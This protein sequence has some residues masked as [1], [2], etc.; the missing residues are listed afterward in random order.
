MVRSEIPEAVVLENSHN[1]GFAAANNQ[2]IRRAR[3]EFVLL[4]NPDTEI[5]PGSLQAMVDFMRATPRAGAA[6]G[7]L[8]NPDGSL[9]AS[10]SP[11]PTLARE[12]W[13]LIH[14]D[15][16]RPLSLYPLTEWS[17]GG[18]RSVDVVQ[19]AALILRRSALDEVGFLDEDYFMYTEEVDLCYR[20]RRSGWEVFWL[21]HAKVLHWGGQS[22][23]QRR[24]E[25][26]LRLYES[27][28]IFFRKRHGRL[29]ALAY[30]LILVLAALPRV[31][32]G[33]LRPRTGSATSSSFQ[34][35]APNY[36]LLLKSLPSL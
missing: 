6:G 36:L 9:Q 33:G 21:P 16:L 4:L 26:F 28:V 7:C 23:R 10:A 12:L 31:V 13:R 11:S 8:V 2:G 15:R 1:S 34:D 29:A 30:K 35:L 19:G 17:A 14:L 5:L 20:L 27:K 22:T 25:M 3:G 32:V 24:S 18:P